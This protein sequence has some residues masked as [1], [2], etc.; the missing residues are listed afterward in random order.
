MRKEPV[1]YCQLDYEN[2]PYP[3]PTS[4]NGNLADNGCGV[5][6]ASMLIENMLGVPFPPKESAYLAKACG[7]REGYGTDLYIYSKALAERF[8]LELTDTE[9]IEEAMA[10]LRAKKGMVIANVRGNREDYIGVFS[11]TGHYILVLEAEEDKIAVLDSC[12]RPGRYDVPGRL[13]KVWMEGN[14]AHSTRDVLEKD[15]FERPFFLFGKGK[16]ESK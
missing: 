4:P 11:D 8:R 5:C 10:F 1:F 13:G 14:I 2:V 7:A 3:S 9:D 6:A 12:Y 16:N 15:C